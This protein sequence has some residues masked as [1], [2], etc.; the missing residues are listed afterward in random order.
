MRRSRRQV[1]SLHRRT[2]TEVRKCRSEDQLLSNLGAAAAD[3]AA[4][5]VFVHRFQIVRRGDESA[6]DQLTEAGRESFQAALDAVGEGLAVLC[7]TAFDGGR[8]VRV[9]PQGMASRGSAAGIDQRLLAN[10]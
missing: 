8:N 3:V 7:P 9:C 1:Q 5:Q 10:N 2:I 4:N 6:A